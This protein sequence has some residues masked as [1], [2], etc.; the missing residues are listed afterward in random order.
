VAEQRL[1]K[2][3]RRLRGE[4]PMPA[5]ERLIAK[6]TRALESALEAVAEDPEAALDRAGAFVGRL[7]DTVEK[8]HE[9]YRRDPAGTKREVRNMVV[10]GLAE[11]GRKKKRRLKR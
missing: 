2:K 8:A 10:G 4:T 6:G 1:V 9:T 11:L 3:K 7:H 5:T